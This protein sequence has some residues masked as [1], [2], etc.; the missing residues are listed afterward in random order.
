MSSISETE[1]C[2]PDSNASSFEETRTMTRTSNLN[3]GMIQGTMQQVHCGDE[4]DEHQQQ[5]DGGRTVDSVRSSL[6]N[7]RQSASR[8][9]GQIR[10]LLETSKALDRDLVSFLHDP[11]TRAFLEYVDDLEDNDN[12]L[13]DICDEGSSDNPKEVEA[14]KQKT[15]SLKR[16][17]R[18]WR[19]AARMALT[20]V[21]PDM[22]TDAQGDMTPGTMKNVLQK[23]RQLKSLT[24]RQ[25]SIIMTLTSQCEAQKAE[26]VE[27]DSLVM[28]LLK[29]CNGIRPSLNAEN[30]NQPFIMSEATSNIEAM[31]TKHENI[32]Y[33]FEPHADLDEVLNQTGIQFG[34][35]PMIPDQLET[36]TRPNTVQSNGTN[37]SDMIAPPLELLNNN[38]EAEPT[39]VQREL[40]DAV[41][42][43]IDPMDDPDTTTNA[44][45]TKSRNVWLGVAVGAAAGLGGVIMG[46]LN[47][48]ANKN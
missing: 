34:I 21:C 18:K 25:T 33:D 3:V 6:S 2:P 37:V 41:S 24:E 11:Q 29:N 1:S 38:R 35:F 43:Q 46:N 12:N 15:K 8:T 22:T 10:E 27:K 40:P 9:T 39:I 31:V 47:R 5:L 32:D 48:R 26:S 20:E 13:L 44:S 36:Q 4:T 7:F 14:L 17:L 19:K 45:M 42:Y 16:K 30:Q 28:E 23:I